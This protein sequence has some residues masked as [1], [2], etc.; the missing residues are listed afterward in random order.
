VANQLTWNGVRN[1]SAKGFGEEVPVACNN[2]IQGFD[3]NR[4]VE[5]WIR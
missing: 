4:R 2:T 5:A 1:V 3:K